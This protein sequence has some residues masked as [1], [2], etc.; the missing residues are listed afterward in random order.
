MS[1]SLRTFIDRIQPL[2]EPVMADLMAACE[3][4]EFPKNYVLLRQGSPCDQ[5]Y[6]L[7]QGAMRYYYTDGDNHETNVW[8]SIDDDV[9]TDSSSLVK[10][11]PAGMSIQLLEDAQMYRI[12]LEHVEELLLKHH[13]FALW[14]IQMIYRYHILRVEERLNEL[15]FFTARQRYEKLIQTFP[16]ITNRISLGHIASYL[17]ITQE[18]LSRIRR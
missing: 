8:F 6:F 15:Q 14:H 5:M 16:G 10:R 1:A 3:W 7:M 4:M 17:N 11:A 2:P 13:A 18:T 12:R 9:V